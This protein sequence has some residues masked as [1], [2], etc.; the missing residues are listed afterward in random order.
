MLIEMFHTPLFIW[1]L[2]LFCVE[3]RKTKHLT[4]LLKKKKKAK[5]Q[6]NKNINPEIL[7]WLEETLFLNETIFLAVSFI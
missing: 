5:K 6:M 3:N 2:T 1:F 7:F 4:H